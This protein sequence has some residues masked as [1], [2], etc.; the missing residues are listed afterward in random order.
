MKARKCRTCGIRKVV[1]ILLIMLAAMSL[2]CPD[3][4]T[5]EQLIRD[6]THKNADVRKSAAKILGGRESGLRGKADGRTV[7]A[8]VAV[9]KDP[10]ASVR[11]EV[12]RAL[13]QIRD[14]RAVEA[15]A[16]AL[17]DAEGCVRDA[18]ADALGQIGDPRAIDPLIA[19]MNDPGVGRFHV[20]LAL[21]KI[22]VIDTRAVKPLMEALND[23][24]CQVRRLAAVWLGVIADPRAVGPLVSGLSDPLPNV[25]EAVVEALGGI[26]RPAVEPLIA[27]LKRKNWEHQYSVGKALGGIGAPAVESVIAAVKDP[28]PEVRKS[29]AIALAYLATDSRAK[30]VLIAARKDGKLE[31]V[32]GASEFFIARGKRGSEGILIHA[33]DAWGDKTTAE[34]FINSHN[35]VLR[36]AGWRWGEK[37][38]YSWKVSPGSPVRW[39]SSPTK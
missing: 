29:A 34:R 22:G 26:G 31:I 33:L 27:E 16:A 23:R 2:G 5:R 6:L 32:A 11:S 30:D 9:L 1:W 10:E 24:D 8:L 13:G 20:M 19:V 21:D 4:R 28:D 35:N 14:A 25:R 38:G 37:H 18:V 3:P 36:D 7:E 17:K 39:G 12:A 15:L